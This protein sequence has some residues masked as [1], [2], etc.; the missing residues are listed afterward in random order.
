MRGRIDKV[1]LLARVYKLKNALH[2]QK[3]SMHPKEYEGADK[4][5]NSILDI[6]NEYTS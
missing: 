2:S 5:L 6:L 4:Q 1:T 3:H